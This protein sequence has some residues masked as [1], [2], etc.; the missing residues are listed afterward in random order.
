MPARCCGLRP[1]KPASAPFLTSAPMRASS[2]RTCCGPGGKGGSS[3][4]SRL[5][6]RMRFS[7]SAPP[8]TAAAGRSRRAS[9]SARRKARRRSTSRSIR[10]ALAAQGRPPLHRRR[11]RLGLRGHRAR[12]GSPPRR[13]DRARLGGAVR[14][15][16]RHAGL[17]AGG[18]E[19][20][21][22]YAGQD[23]CGLA[24]IVARRALRRRR[25]ARRGLR[26]HGAGWFPLHLAGRGLLGFRASRGAAGGRHL[27]PRRAARGDRYADRPVSSFRTILVNAG[28]LVSDRLVRLILNFVVGI[29]IARHLGP[30]GFGLLSYGQVLM[31]LLLPFATFGMPDILVREFSKSKR[32]PETILATALTLSLGFACLAFLLISGIALASRAGDSVAT[33]VILAYG[34]SFFPQTLDVVESRF[35]S[36]NRVGAISTIRM[37]NTVVFSLVRLGALY[38]RFLR[39][40]VRPALLGGNPDFRAAASLWV[41]PIARQIR[42]RPT[43][44]DRAEARSLV[45]DSWPLML[46]LLTISIYMRIQTS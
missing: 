8:G 23:Q 40:V 17:R 25:E 16:D 41:P 7:P 22:R 29:L 20:R 43:L 35:Q 31:T 36:L 46:R 3:P 5:R 10:S 33:L 12:P 14:P 9:R 4:S 30:E 11:P 28:W 19:G 15:Q 1:R 2:A 21:F 39:P 18:A 42:I 38:P 13:D 32:D 34:L 45:T 27:R 24:R 6:P 37:V 26:L 44:V